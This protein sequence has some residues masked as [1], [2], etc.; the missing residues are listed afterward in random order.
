MVPETIAAYLAIMSIGGIALP[1]FSGFGPHA[2]AERL[3]DARAKAAI[4]ADHSFRRGRKVPMLEV[5]E[6]AVRSVPTLE[7]VI[8]VERQPGSTPAS[9]GPRVSWSRLIGGASQIAPL[10]LPAETPAMI[11]YTSGTTGKPKGTVHSHCGFLTKVAL[12]FGIILDLQPDDRLLWM[13]D[14]GWLTGPILAV[15]APLMGAT[16]V[17]AEG[18]PDYPEPGRLWKLVEQHRAS[19]L[20]VAPTMIRT[21]MQHPPETARQYDFGSLRITAATGEPWTPEAWN[22]FCREIGRGRVPLLNY[23][24][25][26]EIGGGILAG[27]VL[28]EKMKPCGFSGP[29]PGMGAVVVD[30]KGGRVARGQVGELALCAPSIGLTRGFW[31]DPD[32]YLETYWSRVPGLWMHGD[33]ASIDEDGVWYIHGRSDDTI[34]IAGKRIG[35]AEVEAALLSTGKI[36]EAAAV[37]VPEPI[38][39]TAVVCICVPAKHPLAGPE[40]ISE[41][42]EAVVA[43]LGAS[44][45]PKDVIFVSD[46]PKTRTMKI[47][48]RL[49]R[50]VLVGEA[51]GDL[52]GLVNPESIE[53][54]KGQAQRA[55]M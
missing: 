33:F 25:G 29:I 17:L 32:R 26:T 30:E 42:R 41:L 7:H 19:F 20:G 47:M 12:D 37:G 14:M 48:R 1:L 15:A 9:A 22:W 21:F 45:R 11:V 43:A 27:N 44:F 2:V 50:S 35:P 38:K 55:S 40:L 6:A 5:L 36:A 39:G 18:V 49:V 28:D 23:S 24:G 34:K 4:T 16:L 31:R 3:A 10:E 13:S 51:P 52:S 54:L 46:L 8:V 53:E